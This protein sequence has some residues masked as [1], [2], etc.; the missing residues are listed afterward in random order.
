MFGE[1]EFGGFRY[2]YG[3]LCL[4]VIQFRFDIKGIYVYFFSVEI[5]SSS[6]LLFLKKSF[7]EGNF[8]FLLHLIK[9]I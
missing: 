2:K 1:S 3:D 6:S 9:N 4:V 7:F 8:P 5:S